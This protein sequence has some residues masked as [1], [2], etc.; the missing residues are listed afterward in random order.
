MTPD[1]GLLAAGV[2]LGWLAGAMTVA[3]VVLRALGLYPRHPGDCRPGCGCR[4]RRT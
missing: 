2:V 4:G 3:W 1:A